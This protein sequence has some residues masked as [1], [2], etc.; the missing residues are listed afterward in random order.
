M[1]ATNSGVKAYAE[2]IA[3]IDEEI[4]ERQSDRKDVLAEAKSSGYDPVLVGKVAKIIGMEAER[5]KRAL[6]QYD[7]FGSYLDQAGLK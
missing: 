7:L 5:R 1:T 4:A 6:N 3:R 2:R